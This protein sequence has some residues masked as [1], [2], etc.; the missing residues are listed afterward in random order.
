MMRR[1]ANTNGGSPDDE[2]NG[3]ILELAP[4]LVNVVEELL[5]LVDLGV[6]LGEL[7]L[8]LCQL[9]LRFFDVESSFHSTS[10]SGDYLL[11]AFDCVDERPDMCP[12]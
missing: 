7:G 5:N 2:S 10:Q 4:P 3:A 8:V 9:G 12:N 11:E 1:N 6:C